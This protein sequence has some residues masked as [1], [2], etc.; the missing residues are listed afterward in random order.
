MNKEFWNAKRVF[1]TGHT[2]FK[3]GWLAV[4]LNSMGAKV[5]GYSLGPTESSLFFNQVRVDEVLESEFGDIRDSRRLEASIAKFKPDIIFHLAAQPLVLTSLTEPRETFDVNVMGTVNLLEAV[6]RTACVKAVVNVTTDKCYENKGWSWGYRESDRLGGADPYSSSKSC[7][8]LVTAAYRSSYFHQKDDVGIATAR[9]GNVIGGG[10]LAKDRLLP[11]FF[12]SLK[13]NNPV[14]V[15]NPQATR[16]WQHV[17]EPLVGYCVLAESLFNCPERFAGGWNFGPNS[18]R[19]ASVGQVIELAAQYWG[20]SAKW[21]SKPAKG[22]PEANRLQ[23]DISK[24]L[25]NLEWS[26]VW[27]IRTSIKHTV[28]WHKNLEKSESAL[29]FTLGQ[30]EKYFSDRK[31]IQQSGQ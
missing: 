20:P 26:P 29:N 16:P 21:H 30:I 6:R 22:S 4:L 19:A 5:K 27:D 14:V 3:G 24:S 13:A 15:R 1:I 25:A 8:E 9:A 23:L 31:H 2:G 28:D 11:D 18:L 17:M 12:R 10:D 7:S